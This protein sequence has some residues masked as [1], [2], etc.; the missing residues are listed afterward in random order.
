VVFTDEESVV[1]ITIGD[2]AI[3]DLGI[4]VDCIL[5]EVEPL[6]VIDICWPLDDIIVLVDEISRLLLMSVIFDIVNSD[7]EVPDAVLRSENAV[8]CV[9]LKDS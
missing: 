1:V 4:S 2:V 8:S 7:V 6:D 5:F 3:L 9:D